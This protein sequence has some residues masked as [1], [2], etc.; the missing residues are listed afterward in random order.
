MKTLLNPDSDSIGNKKTIKCN[1]MPDDN[2]GNKAIFTSISKIV[3][4]NIGNIKYQF[5]QHTKKQ[6]L[7]NAKNYNENTTHN[8]D[9]VEI[10]H[11]KVLQT[12]S[13]IKKEKIPP[14]K[15]N[16]TLLK[17]FEINQSNISEQKFSQTPE[18]KI[19]ELEHTL[20]NFLKAGKLVTDLKILVEQ[21]DEI[22]ALHA[23]LNEPIF[24]NN[25][26][27]LAAL[28]FLIS[29]IINKTTN[30]RIKIKISN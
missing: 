25:N 13:N 15:T 4:D 16:K 9:H 5:K 21:K 19:I 17:L 11:K 8:E 22:P 1:K 28:N 6:I 18:K 23:I 29:K 14:E 30:E 7:K 2:I 20:R 12:N 26:L 24:K 27:A 3:P 10:L